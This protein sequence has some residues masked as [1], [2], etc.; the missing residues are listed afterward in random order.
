MS[1]LLEYP[2]AGGS[3]LLAPAKLYPRGPRAAKKRKHIE[4][5]RCHCPTC[6]EL[7]RLPVAKQG[8][9]GSFQ[10]AMPFPAFDYVWFWRAYLGDR[11]GHRCRVLARGKMN[12]ILVEFEDGFRAITSR[13]AVRRAPIATEET[14][15]APTPR[16]PESGRLL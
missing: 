8:W 6:T 12:S 3:V 16:C 5:P 2:L 1:D 14:A 11:R 10:L 13:Y 15:E 7:D 9:P 4:S